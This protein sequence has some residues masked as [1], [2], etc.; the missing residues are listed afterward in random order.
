MEPREIEAIKTTSSLKEK[1]F[2]TKHNK[3]FLGICWISLMIFLFNSIYVF[4]NEN[5]KL[6]MQES[7]NLFYLSVKNVNTNKQ[8]MT[9]KP[10]ESQIYAMSLKENFTTYKKQKMEKRSE[11]MLT[12]AAFSTREHINIVHE[13]MFEMKNESLYKE[14]T[15]FE[16]NGTLTNTKYNTTLTVKDVTI[17][18]RKPLTLKIH[19]Q[20]LPHQVTN[21]HDDE[22]LINEHMVCDMKTDLLVIIKTA[23]SHLKHREI[24]RKTWGIITRMNGFS[25]RH[26]FLLGDAG[27][28][29]VND[30]IQNESRIY[31]DIIQGDYKD[32]YR[33]LTLKVLQGLKWATD[34][35]KNV[36]YILNTDD[37]VFV[38]I[39]SL[40]ILIKKL[41]S[42]GEQQNGL[43]CSVWVNTRPIRN[44][45]SKWYVTKTQFE[46]NKYPDYCSGM[47]VLYTKNAAF[48]IYRASLT[49]P[50][51]WVD[52]VYITGVLAAKAGIPHTHIKLGIENWNFW[53]MKS[54][55][56]KFIAI[57]L[58]KIQGMLEIWQN[59][60]MP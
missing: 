8:K 37:D 24:I 13:A 22:F 20:N 43:F 36:T 2:L 26:I 25:L 5:T 21:Q 47:A 3:S 40:L 9:M 27:S 1:M 45:N 29:S 48:A 55:P 17:Q 53:P 23:P 56:K 41:Q 51:F 60:K 15:T 33:N 44:P 58:K 38:N 54:D 34:F 52:D 19:T 18:Q 4:D 12:P 10:N 14:Q 46:P 42:N 32:A 7:E 16:P 50:F 59:I 6:I 35:C 49:V 57:E 31:R 11:S 28:K 30:A 39:P